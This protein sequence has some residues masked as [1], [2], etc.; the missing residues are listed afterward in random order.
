MTNNLITLGFQVVPKSKTHDTYALVD[1][2]IEVIQ[3]S[4]IK[5][6]ITPFETVLEGEYNELLQLTESAQQ[7]V[8]SAGADECLVYIRLHYRK[9]EDVTFE[10][11]RL[12][13]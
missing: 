3:E 13:R 12:D 9:G 7:A 11:K 2:A 8:L 10:E 6:V 5:H 4:G 1:K